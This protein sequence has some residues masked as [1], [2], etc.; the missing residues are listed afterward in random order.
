MFGSFNCSA[1]VRG[2]QSGVGLIVHRG[3]TDLVDRQ[4]GPVIFFFLRQAQRRYLIDQAVND[5]AANQCHGN[6]GQGTDQLCHKA[7]AAQTT[8][9]LQTEDTGG[10]ATP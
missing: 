5:K 7:N 1:G 10:Y 3:R 9:A 8:Q 4:I 2:G 6:A